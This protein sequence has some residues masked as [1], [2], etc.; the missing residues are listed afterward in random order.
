MILTCPECATRYFVEDSRLSGEGRTVRWAACKSSWHAK[1]TEP[2]ELTNDET[3]GT[4]V[5]DTLSFKPDE[6]VGVP[7][8]LRNRSR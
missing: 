6:P 3:A 7:A 4:V 2:L 5:R 8:D 1:A